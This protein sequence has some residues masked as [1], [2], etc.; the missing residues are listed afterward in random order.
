MDRFA[1]LCNHMHV[2]LVRQILRFKMQELMSSSAF[3]M[4]IK[5]K[6]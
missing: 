1:D 3:V 2:I 4:S 5:G 6:K